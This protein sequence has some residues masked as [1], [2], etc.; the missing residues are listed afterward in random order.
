MKAKQI[1]LD[2]GMHWGDQVADT[3]F[4][5]AE[6]DIDRHWCEMVDPTLCQLSY[7]V[8]VDIA[9]GRGRNSSKLA[10]FAQHIIMRRY[11]SDNVR[12]MEIQWR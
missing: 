8:V 5:K 6:T 12:C 3:Y 4:R 11:Q 9:A 1:A 10:Q 7:N 2:E